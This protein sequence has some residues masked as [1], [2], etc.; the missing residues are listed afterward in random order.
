MAMT[1]H[2]G[3]LYF[4]AV[5]DFTNQDLLVKTIVITQ[6]SATTLPV[7]ITTGDGVDTLFFVDTALSGP[8]TMTFDPPQRFPRGIEM[9]VGTTA[10]MTVFLA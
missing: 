3:I 7:E 9:D 6:V 5:G 10:A 8:V 1:K 4:G 2:D